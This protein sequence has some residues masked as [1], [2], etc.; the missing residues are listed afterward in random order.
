MSPCFWLHWWLPELTSAALGKQRHQDL[1]LLHLGWR[2]Q[3]SKSRKCSILWD[4]FQQ[5]EMLKQLLRQTMGLKKGG[6]SVTQ[7]CNILF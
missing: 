6:V 2:G 7:I 3:C 1:V 4:Y 5:E